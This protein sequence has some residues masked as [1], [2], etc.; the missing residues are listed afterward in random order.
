LDG[1]EVGAEFEC[2]QQKCNSGAAGLD[3]SEV[4]IV[5]LRI[6][7]AAPFVET[8]ISLV[9]CQRL[10]NYDLRIAITNALAIFDWHGRD[11]SGESA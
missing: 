9:P 8:D 6:P 5:R 10:R 3:N 7:R 4:F 11:D 2:V 1:R